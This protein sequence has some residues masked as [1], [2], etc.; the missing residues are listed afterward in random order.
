[1]GMWS[2]LAIGVVIAFLLF[3]AGH[4]YYKTS[5]GKNKLTPKKKR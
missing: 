2:F 3:R 4:H 5:R 1:M